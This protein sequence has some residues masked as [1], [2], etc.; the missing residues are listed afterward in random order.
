[1]TPER[2]ARFFPDELKADGEG[3]AQLVMLRLLHKVLCGD[4]RVSTAAQFA[5]FKMLL[6]WRK[7]PRA[8]AA[9]HPIGV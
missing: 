2:F 5:V 4:D 1:V 6:D 9:K 8:T 3:V 7:L